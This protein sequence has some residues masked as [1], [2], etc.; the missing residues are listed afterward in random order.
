MT[1][2]DR[3]K[4]T[5]AAGSSVD[6]TIITVFESGIRRFDRD[7]SSTSGGTA[8]TVHRMACHVFEQVPAATRILYV[9]TLKRHNGILSGTVLFL[10]EAAHQWF[11]VQQN[12]CSIQQYM[13]TAQ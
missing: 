7:L 11:D 3:I 4:V 9:S 5:N 1:P 2:G 12:R 13:G 6:A 8:I 10:I